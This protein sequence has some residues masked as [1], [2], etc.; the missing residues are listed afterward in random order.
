M[1]SAASGDAPRRFADLFPDASSD[2]VLT[3]S[4]D[5]VSLISHV[6]AKTASKQAVLVGWLRHYGCTLCKKQTA[7]WRD[8]APRLRDCGNVALVLVGNGTPE[9]AREF[10]EE[11]SWE[12]DMFTDPSRRTYRALQFSTGLGVTFNLPALGKVITSIKEGN[13]QTWSRLPTDGFQQGGAVLIDRDGCVQL[14]HAD[15]FAGD[16]VDL[17]EL[18]EQTCKACTVPTTV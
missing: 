17:D 18:F 8:L 15:A 1:S 7:D 13:S 5:S 14:F 10:V 4:G 16:H 11:M 12:G 3:L 9:Q 2:S 6:G